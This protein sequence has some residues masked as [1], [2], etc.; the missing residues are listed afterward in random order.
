MSHIRSAAKVCFKRLLQNVKCAFPVYMN[1]FAC[2]KCELS[3]THEY[4]RS[5]ISAHCI[6]LPELQILLIYIQIF[7]VLLPTFGCYCK[8][9]TLRAPLVSSPLPSCLCMPEG[10][11]TFCAL[12][13]N[14]AHISLMF[15]IVCLYSCL[16]R[17]SPVGRLPLGLCVK[18]MSIC[19]HISP[20]LC[21]KD[22]FH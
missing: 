13:H 15:H 16:L 4:T 12:S 11:P 18:F 8:C 7:T 21:L 19:G 10:H 14:P 22:F 2:V 6:D 9:L 17:C 1:V 5:L 3:G 20:A